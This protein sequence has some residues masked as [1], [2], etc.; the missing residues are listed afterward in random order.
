MYEP[1]LNNMRDA[2]DV[3]GLSFLSGIFGGA[4]FLLGVVAIII[5]ILVVAALYIYQ[6]LA[7]TKI[8][9]DMKYKDAWLAWIPFGATIMRLQLGKKF[10]WAWAFL[11]LIP[12]VG[13][14][15]IGVLVTIS[16]WG[17]FEKR[18]YPGWLSLSYVGMCLPHLGE[19][20]FLAYMVIIGFVAWRKP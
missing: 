13:W 11:W 17:I 4:F 1:I 18:K 8:A 3:M 5:A 10:H 7:W 2:A 19:I 14:I 15:A 12:V 20:I 16:I 6:A 9:R